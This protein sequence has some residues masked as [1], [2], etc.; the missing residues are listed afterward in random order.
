MSKMGA[1][2]PFGH[3]KHKLWQKKKGHKKLGIDSISWLPDGVQHTIGKLS[4]SAT[5]LI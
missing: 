4:T 5:T 2:D 1:H 3:L